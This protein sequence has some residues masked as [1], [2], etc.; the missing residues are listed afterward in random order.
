MDIVQ[1]YL[2]YRMGGNSISV[3]DNGIGITPENYE[4]IA[5][6]HFTSKI[7]EF[8]DL[9]VLSS[10]GFRGEALNALCELSNKVCCTTKQ[11]N[12]EMGNLLNFNR[13][14]T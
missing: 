12:Q 13:D 9:S 10:F 2:H 6:K 3:S 5:L 7:S 1:L 4:K 8:D 11:S 14:G